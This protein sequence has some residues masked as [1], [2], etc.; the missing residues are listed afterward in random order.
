[1]NNRR[2][3]LANKGKPL[4]QTILMSPS[5]HE[6]ECITNHPIPLPL[7]P[8]LEVPKSLY[9]V[10]KCNKLFLRCDK[11][12]IQQT[13]QSNYIRIEPNQENMFNS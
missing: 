1:M 11:T 7:D 6:L 4:S 13:I 12:Y 2:V 5:K 9:L 8:N 3:K 10:I